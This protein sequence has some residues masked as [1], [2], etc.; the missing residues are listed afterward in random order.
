LTRTIYTPLDGAPFAGLDVIK[1]RLD[2]LRRS[3]HGRAAIRST[4]VKW[5]WVEHVIAQG[6]AA[7]GRAILDAVHAG[8]D[9]A[10]FRK[11]L[12]AVDPGRT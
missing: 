12:S 8:G 7:T 2:R 4:S 6:G 9:Y 10:A 11:A 3:L 1:D 5:A